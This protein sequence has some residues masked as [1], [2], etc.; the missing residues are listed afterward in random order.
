VKKC[1]GCHEEETKF[2]RTTEHA[3]AYEVLAREDKQFNLDCVGCHVT[4]YDKPGGSTVTHVDGLKDNQC[5]NCHG[6]GSLHAESPTK[7]GLIDARPE[8]S[9]CASECHHPPH[10]QPNWNVD[11]AWKKILGPGH[12]G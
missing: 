2:W 4:G 12:G 6:P 7:K 5:E 11:E 10:V 1:Q 8:R 3:G 9:L